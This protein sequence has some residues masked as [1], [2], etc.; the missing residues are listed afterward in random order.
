MN[1]LLIYEYQG[2]VYDRIDHTNTFQTLYHK[3]KAS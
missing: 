3:F 1:D 2:E